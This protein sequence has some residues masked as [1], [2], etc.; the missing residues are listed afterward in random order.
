[1]VTYW[2]IFAWS[3]S[4]PWASISCRACSISH[5]IPCTLYGKLGHEALDVIAVYRGDSSVVGLAVVG[6]DRAE[7]RLARL[8]GQ[9]PFWTARHAVPIS[10]RCHIAVARR[11]WEL[12]IAR[13]R[14]IWVCGMEALAAPI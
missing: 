4:S 3:E 8:I 9:W 13:A 11:L 2:L 1:V 6:A 5:V 14:G 12:G 10:S 7:S